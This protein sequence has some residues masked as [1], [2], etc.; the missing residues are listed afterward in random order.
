M[1]ENSTITKSLQ[2]IKNEKLDEAEVLLRQQLLK[3]PSQLQVLNILGQVYLHKNDSSSAIKQL[4]KSVRINPKDYLVHYHLGLAYQKNKEYLKAINSFE[5]S[6]KLNKNNPAIYKSLGFVNAKDHYYSTAYDY[7]KK[8]LRHFRNDI[9]VLT[10]LFYITKKLGL[11]KECISYSK[12][13]YKL[14]DSPENLM[15][16]IF[17]S[18]K[19]PDLGLADFKLLA[20]EYYNK[21]LKRDHINADFSQ[22]LTAKKCLKIGFV[23]YD[24]RAHPVSTFLISILER[25]NK[26]EFEIVLYS[27]NSKQD[28]ITEKFKSIA[29]TFREIHELNDLDAANLIHNDQVDILFD[30]SGFTLG[31]RLGVFAHKAAPLQISYI[32]YFGTLAMPEMDYIIADENL[33]KENEEQFFTEKILKLNPCFTHANLIELST[34]SPKTAFSKNGF[35]TFG[36]SNRWYKVSEATIKAWSEILKQV[37]ASKFLLNCATFARECNRTFVE[38][39]FS[40]YGIK[41]DRLIFKHSLPREEFL[42]DYKEI[43]ILLDP[44]PYGGGTTSLE[45][46]LNGV[47][48]IT[49]DGDRWVSRMTS[50]KLKAIGCNELVAKDKDEYIQ[51][52]VNLAQDREKIKNYR[53]TLNSRIQN[54]ELNIDKFTQRFEKALKDIWQKESNKS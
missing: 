2:L 21:F 42:E 25:L 3:N 10:N 16:L 6:Y 52:A 30:L 43:D 1:Q 7:Y 41:K 51:L 34:A 50:T 4:E 49:I 14:Q 54:S 8:A 18:H 9:E 47:P 20:E 38:N 26:D 40:K 33:V 46:L 36:C 24:L 29:S 11:Y 15:N 28:H 13:L 22:Q 31:H 45:S 32:G 35:I 27:T 19:D 23:S 44:F 39:L 5:A 48:V 53:L 12:E 37:P 17:N